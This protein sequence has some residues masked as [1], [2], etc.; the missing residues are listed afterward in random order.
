MHLTLLDATGFRF[1]KHD[2]LMVM[3]AM[4]TSWEA[5]SRY[6]QGV[7]SSFVLLDKAWCIF[8]N[9]E[10]AFLELEAARNESDN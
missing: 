1:E 9:M 8:E 10:K 2:D 5:E 6:G 4:I 7:A 3:A